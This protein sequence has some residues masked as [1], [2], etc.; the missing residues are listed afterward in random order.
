MG[1][2][3][4]RG[5]RTTG[6]SD[7]GERGREAI[8]FWEGLSKKLERQIG[9]PQE[10]GNE[11]LRERKSRFKTSQSRVWLGKALQI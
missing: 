2:E 11:N 7:R 9:N 8:L 6:D 10:R 3:Q 4:Q 5:R 1:K